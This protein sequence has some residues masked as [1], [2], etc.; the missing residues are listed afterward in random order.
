MSA[1]RKKVRKY[2][3]PIWMRLILTGVLG[4]ML[5]IRVTDSAGD[6]GVTNVNSAMLGILAVLI[7]A[8]WFI[9]FS[10]Y[11]RKWRFGLPVLLVVLLVAVS[12]LIQC[13]RKYCA[14]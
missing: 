11:A 4:Y 13:F 14:T 1:E 5:W 12:F 6:Q 3:P 10:A 2:W 8:P 9:F 7:L